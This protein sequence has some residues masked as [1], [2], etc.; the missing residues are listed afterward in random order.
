MEVKVKSNMDRAMRGLWNVKTKY[1]QKALVTSLNKIGAEVVTQAKRELKD[2]TGLK[3]GVVGKKIKKDKARKGDETYSIYIKSR[4]LNAIEFGARQTKKGV[5]AK[6][7]NIRKNYKGA[8][9]GSG[10]N[11]G[12]QLVFGKSKK[13]KNKLKALHGASL[14]REFH[15]EDMAKIFNKKIK[16]RFSILFKRA[17][18]FHLMKAKERV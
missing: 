13:K 6:I 10:R 15:R 11:S 3:A 16:T 9:I 5:S 4:Y 1:I 18:E 17:L 2:A 14:P 12:K 8:F 7:W